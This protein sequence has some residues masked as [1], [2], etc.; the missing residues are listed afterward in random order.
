MSESSWSSEEEWATIAAM[1]HDTQENG[2]NAVEVDTY[3]LYL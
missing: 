2:S 3:K 1:V